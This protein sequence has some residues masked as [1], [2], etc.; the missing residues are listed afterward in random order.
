MRESGCRLGNESSAI[1][2]PQ[3][4]VQYDQQ[5]SYVLIVDGNNIAERRN[6]KIGP[7]KDH[8]YVIENGLTGEERVVTDGVLKAIPGKPVTP[9]NRSGSGTDRQ[10][11]SRGAQ[12]ISEFFVDR[13][14]FANVIA[15]VTII[16]GLIA[17]YILPVSQYPNI[18]PPTIQISTRYPGASADVVAKTVGTPIEQ[19]V[20]GVE[21]SIYMSSVSGSDG[22]Y[23][24]TITFDVGT[25]LDTSLALV[26]NLVSTALAQLPTGS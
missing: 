12:M 9:L 7:R 10:T 18:V 21:G 3:V 16:I 8:S 25:N 14:I 4:A 13:P 17:L 23:S 11:R 1:L 20:N 5:G 24:L 26:Q 6:V 15:F 22:S 19:A 2:I